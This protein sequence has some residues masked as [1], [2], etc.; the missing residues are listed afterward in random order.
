MR[1][2][3]ARAVSLTLA[4]AALALVPPAPPAVAVGEAPG[5]AVVLRT[6][7]IALLSD[8]AYAAAVAP[9]AATESESDAQVLA[10]KTVLVDRLNQVFGEELAI[11]FVLAPG[12]ADLNLR[13]AAEATGANG[14]CGAQPCFT[15]EQLTAC[16]DDA[17]LRTRNV[18]GQLLGARNYEI[19]HLVLGTAAGGSSYPSTAGTEYRAYGCSG[20]TTPTGDGFVLDRLAH[21][22][23]HQL[24]ASATFDGTSCEEERNGDTAVEPGSG[25]SVMGGPGACGVDDLQ[26]DAD[27]WF[28]N[29]SQDEIGLYVVGDGPVPEDAVA[30]EVQSVA[31]TGFDGSD[32]FKLSFG[33]VQTTTFTRGVNYNADAIKAAVLAAVPSAVV[34]KVRPF[35]QTG[36]FDDRGFEMTF[37]SFQ[38]VVEPTVVPVAGSFTAAVNDIDAGGLQL[39]GGTTSA[40]GNHNPVVTAPADR[41]I[42]VRTPFAL[43]GSATDPDSDPLVHQWQQ[44]DAG[45][46]DGRALAD[47]A[48]TDGPLFRT[49]APTASATRVFPDL[50]QV[51]AGNTNAATGTCA[52]HRLLR[53][54]AA[55]RGVRVP[56][57]LPARRPGPEG[58]G[59]RGRRRRRHAH[60]RHDDRAVPGHQPVAAGVGGRRDRAAGHLDR[61]HRGAG[62]ERE[63]QPLDRRRPDVRDGAGG[64]HPQRRRAHRHAARGLD[65]RRPD[66]GRGGRQLLLRRQPRGPDDHPAAVRPD[67]D[68]RAG[69]RD[70]AAL[71]PA[72]CSRSPPSPRTP[73]SAR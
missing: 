62:G 61:Q 46:V 3:L 54:V 58:R 52:E 28:A 27:P 7:R 59:R 31:F 45:G 13:N 1:R 57:A 38:N 39:P 55:H 48:K 25:S 70:G 49:L 30:A 6:Y 36:T 68:R 67:R 12:S 71:G 51:V 47:P 15:T 9:G 22:L 23:G 66:Q 34:S 65:R 60:R 40:T 42:P 14:P 73:R 17:M 16:T 37:A 43:S 8:P 63:D 44:V 24:G 18:V 56:A 64:E 11:R 69:L 2:V 5:A 19:G 21:E 4:V 32:A 41:T 20:S 26:A 33:G 10:A 29:V 72:R 53:G 50:A 35:W